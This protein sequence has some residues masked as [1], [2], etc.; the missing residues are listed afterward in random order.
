MGQ[1]SDVSHSDINDPVQFQVESY[2][3]FKICNGLWPSLTLSILRYGSS[4]KWS[5]T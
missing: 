2:Q 4:V 1:V 3:I 5:N